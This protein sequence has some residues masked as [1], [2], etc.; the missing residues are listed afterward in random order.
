MAGRD[1]LQDHRRDVARRKRVQAPPIKI[2]SSG[3]I[4][5][6]PV[7]SDTK[8]DLSRTVQNTLGLYDN[9]KGKS[10]ESSLLGVGYQPQTPLPGENKNISHFPV[11]H[12]QI[13]STGQHSSTP[14]SSGK[15]SSQAKNSP[16][17]ASSLHRHGSSKPAPAGASSSSSKGVKRESGTASQLSSSSTST[18]SSKS[19]HP[20]MFDKSKDSNQRR[21]KDGSSGVRPKAQGSGSSVES[22]SSQP[23]S[24]S[25]QSSK[26][27]GTMSSSS[28]SKPGSSR[29]SSSNSTSRGSSSSSSNSSASDSKTV[30]H[31]NGLLTE[32]C[33]SITNYPSKQSGAKSEQKD[34]KQ[35]SGHSKK[36][37]VSFR[38]L[39]FISPMPD[40]VADFQSRSTPNPAR[41]VKKDR[42]G[43]T[44]QRPRLDI[45]K[46][47]THQ[48]HS[49]H[50]EVEQIFEVR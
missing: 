13:K 40:I 28:A 29:P 48:G 2:E 30:L 38:E 33:H 4:F 32:T 25:N 22:S 34:S 17:E 36:D 27:H 1:Q 44:K 24:S 39:P 12:G 21:S 20:S 35:A 3:P 26:Q 9:F 5:G 11:M 6:T 19:A 37:T 23:K 42:D 43:D 31:P 49:K 41:E 47:G 15:S 14:G 45:P 16:A 10:H 50:K 8:D 7:K 46:K 18:S